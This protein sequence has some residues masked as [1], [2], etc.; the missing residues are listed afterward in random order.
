M[1]RTV[2]AGALLTFAYFSLAYYFKISYVEDVPRREDVASHPSDHQDRYP[3]TFYVTS[4]G[5]KPHRD[6][7]RSLYRSGPLDRCR[8]CCL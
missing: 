1:R 5:A 2:V 7:R 6:P 8:K 4:L 3:G